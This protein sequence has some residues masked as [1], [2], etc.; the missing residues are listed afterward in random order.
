MICTKW[1]LDCGVETAWA[2]IRQPD[3]KYM[4]KKNEKGSDI[5]QIILLMGRHCWHGRVGELWK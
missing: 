4:V 5:R 2:Y 3:A 1:G